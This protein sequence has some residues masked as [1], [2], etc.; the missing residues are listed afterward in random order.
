LAESYVK[1]N[2]QAQALP[3]NEKLV[4]EFQ[5]SEHLQDAQKRI[6]ELKAQAANKS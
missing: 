4:S 6:A 3:L 1:S 2:R 5:K